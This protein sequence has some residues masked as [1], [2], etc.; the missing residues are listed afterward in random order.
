MVLGQ[1]CTTRTGVVRAYFNTPWGNARV[2]TCLGQKIKNERKSEAL[3]KSSAGLGTADSEAEKADPATQWIDCESHMIQC[4][5]LYESYSRHL[6]S[7]AEKDDPT[8][9]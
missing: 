1:T 6:L 2:L 9:Q 8:T 5:L 7:E 4:V 3:C